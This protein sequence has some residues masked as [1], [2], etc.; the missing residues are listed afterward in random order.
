MNIDPTKPVASMPTRPKRPQGTALPLA[1]QPNFRLVIAMLSVV[2]V[3]STLFSFRREDDSLP[4]ANL[5]AIPGDR[6]DW[7]YVQ[8]MPLSPDLM[9]EM[10]ADSYVDRRYVNTRTGQNVELLAVYRR[11][12]RREFAH[13]PDQ[14]YPAAGFNITLKDH[15]TLPYAGRAIDVVHITAD[16]RNVQRADG[17]VGMP[18]QTLTYFFASGDRTESDFMKQQFI[19]SIERLVPN[20]NGWTFIRLSSERTTT[21]DDALDAQ[22]DFMRVYGPAIEQRITTDPTALSATPPPDSFGLSQ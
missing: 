18:D 7:R 17:K 2:L 6:G 14:C 16:G 4:T 3:L 5:S 20:K 11:Y 8:E 9:T 22:Q 19:M 10:K 15:A 12:G 13:R 1:P 21:D